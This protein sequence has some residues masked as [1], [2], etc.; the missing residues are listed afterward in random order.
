M[1]FSFATTASSFSSSSSIR[2]PPPL[3][4]KSCLVLADEDLEELPSDEPFVRKSVHF[5]ADE[6]LVQVR[7]IP[8]GNVLHTAH[9]GP[10]IEPALDGSHAPAFDLSALED[11]LPDVE[12]DEAVDAAGTA[13]D[14]SALMEALPDIDEPTVTSPLTPVPEPLEAPSTFNAPAEAGHLRVAV[15]AHD[16]FRPTDGYN[17]VSHLCWVLFVLAF[18]LP[19]LLPALLGVRIEAGVSDCDRAEGSR[20]WGGSI[21][22]ELEWLVGT[23]YESNR[24]NVSVCERAEG[25]G[26]CVGSIGWRRGW[27]VGT[28]A[29]TRIADVSVCERAEGSRACV[30]VIC[31]P[32]WRGKHSECK[33]VGGGRTCGLSGREDET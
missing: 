9:H 16:Q 20:A 15:Q 7:L 12:S 14:M 33:A 6:D 21:M 4:L 17:W 13:F 8:P 27:L 26:T 28:V 18:I 32:A 23:D 30:G 24:S 2:R 22:G 3:P 19:G 29:A 31:S 10:I 25:S 5:P 11:A 1:Q